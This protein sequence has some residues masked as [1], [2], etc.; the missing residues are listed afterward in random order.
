MYK[1][2]IA[3]IDVGSSKIVAAA[4]ERD[5]NGTIHVL[6]LET[7]STG[8]S[9][10]RGRIHNIDEVSLKIGALLEKLDH[11][12]NGKVI[13]VYVGVGGQSLITGSYPETEE[14]EESAI[15]EQ[16]LQP[17]CENYSILGLSSLKLNL[18][19]CISKKND[20]E[21]AGYFISPIATATAVL[22]EREKNLGCALIEFGAG[23]TYLSIYKEGL[24]KYL[25]AIPLGGNVIT[26]DIC[27][28]EILENEAEELKVIYGSALMETSDENIKLQDYPDKKIDIE[29]LNYIIESRSNEIIANIKNLLEKSG[30]SDTLGGGIVITGGA[31]A[32]KNLPESIE[33]KKLLRQSVRI[34]HVRNDLVDAESFHFGQTFGNEVT[35]GLLFLG[36]ENCVEIVKNPIVSKPSGELF[37][38]REMG[39]ENHTPEPPV[40]K[41]KNF[42]DKIKKAVENTA[43]TL[44]D[45]VEDENSNF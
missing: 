7:E 45:G 42:I 33:E 37:D 9:V 29:E 36:T 3:T 13:K 39:T 28:L 34:A 35:F 25:V 19:T 41:K 26:K 32:L 30:F 12:L 38:E 21:I 14:A 22:T 17:L 8:D 6:A 31:A 4:G 43:G 15:D 40:K 10:R 20:I 44:F 5:E 2:I 18:H 24:L 23:I 27:S 1:E 16:L 11:K